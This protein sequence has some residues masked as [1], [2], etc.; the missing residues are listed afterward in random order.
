M[1]VL[2]D[3]DPWTDLWFYTNPIWVAAEPMTVTGLDLGHRSTCE[4]EH[5]L[6]NL[7]PVP[8]LV[9][10]THL[11][12]DGRPRVVLT[13]QAPSYPRTTRRTRWYGRR[14]PTIGPAA[15]A[16]RSAT[17]GWRS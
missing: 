9:A 11:V 3:A 1:D 10:C 2:G 7:P 6:A 5:W 15:V 4:A 13:L 16:G 12:H 17:P 14:S 8:G